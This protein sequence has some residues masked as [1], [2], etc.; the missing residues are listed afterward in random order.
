MKLLEQ[1]HPHLA[2]LEAFEDGLRA[3]FD[4]VGGTTLLRPKPDLL[5]LV[6]PQGDTYIYALPVP[7]SSAPEGSARP[8]CMLSISSL[9]KDRPRLTD[10][11][12]N[13]CNRFAA[14]SHMTKHNDQPQVMAANTFTIFDDPVQRAISL[15]VGLQTA[16]AQRTWLT[17]VLAGLEDDF[18]RPVKMFDPSSGTQPSRW[19]PEEIADLLNGAIEKG[20]RG[21]LI[22]PNAMLLALVRKPGQGSL[23]LVRNDVVHPFYGNGLSVTLTLPEESGVIKEQLEQRAIEWNRRE[24][25]TVSTGP[26]VGAW[27]SR[28]DKRQMQNICFVPNVFYTPGIG[29]M[30]L[31]TMLQRWELSADLPL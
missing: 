30:V 12:I 8:L 2:S 23:V 28:H 11:Q 15:Y 22:D 18:R 31:D 21:R 14:M 4:A 26:C 20:Y 6:E 3:S 10:E 29:K 1:R 5:H 27:S 16:V 17:Q 25:V 19:H 24:S 7:A 9:L 13:A